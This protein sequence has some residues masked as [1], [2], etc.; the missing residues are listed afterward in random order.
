MGDAGKPYMRTDQPIPGDTR[1]AATCSSSSYCAS[2]CNFPSSSASC[3]I[4][5]SGIGGIPY[6]GYTLRCVHAACRTGPEKSVSMHSMGMALVSG[7]QI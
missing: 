4:R 7:I 1:Y 6:G 5:L 2:G 3:A